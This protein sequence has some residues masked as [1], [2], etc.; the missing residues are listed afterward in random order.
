M[1]KIAFFDFDGTVTKED[2]LFL[3]IRYYVGD[4][5]FFIGLI[6]LSPVLAGYVLKLI[7][8][9][10]A[11][12]IVLKY[13]FVGEDETVFNKKAKEFSLKH[14]PKTLRSQAMEKIEEYKQEGTK[15]VIVSASLENWLKPWCDS[16]SLDL[17]A[18]RVTF[19]NGKFV[20][21]YIPNNC[22]GK[23]KVR[24]IKDSYDLSSFEKIYGYGDTSGDL[25]MLELADESFYKPFR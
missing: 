10:V 5:K 20:G 13:F 23:E 8:N 1:S 2:T 24:R 3:F 22:H 19:E 12:Q 14:M 15:V 21:E 11:K 16:E 9:S 6:I 4:L 25:P 18:T 7:N 17:L